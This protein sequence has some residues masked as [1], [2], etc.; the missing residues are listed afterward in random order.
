MEGGGGGDPEVSVATQE[1]ESSLREEKAAKKELEEAE[2]AAPGWMSNFPSS[3]LR[4]AVGSLEKAAAPHRTSP[5]RDAAAGRMDD[6]SRGRQRGR[7]E[8]PPQEEQEHGRKGHGHGHGQGKD[9]AAAT[10]GVAPQAS[11]LVGK[12]REG[13]TDDVMLKR[14]E[15]QFSTALTDAEKLRRRAALQR[16]EAKKASQEHR[17]GS[18]AAPESCGLTSCVKAAAAHPS[19]SQEARARMGISGGKG[20]SEGDKSLLGAL[21]SK[22]TVIHKVSTDEGALQRLIKRQMGVVT[23]KIA[24]TAQKVHRS[25]RPA[26]G[27]EEG[28]RQE[29]FKR[30]ESV[31]ATRQAAR[32]LLKV[33]HGSK[34]PW[35]VKTLKHIASDA[36]QID[37]AKGRID[38]IKEGGVME[39]CSVEIEGLPKCATHR[40]SAK[41]AEEREKQEAARLLQHTLD[42]AAAAKKKVQEGET[43]RRRLPASV[44]AQLAAAAKI[45]EG[46]GKRKKT[47]VA[48]PAKLVRTP[49][50]AKD[51]PSSWFSAKDQEEAVPG[52]KAGHQ[53][54]GRAQN[55]SRKGAKGESG[56]V[57][58]LGRDVVRDLSQLF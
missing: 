41:E 42:L 47:H 1:F 56:V 2:E 9:G 40:Q 25:N 50:E 58:E 43:R 26:K 15:S 49:E 31:A 36:A 38:R 6:G 57:G 27:G 30:Q 46:G 55:G 23:G 48:A 32:Q 35:L 13:T 18:S 4:S 11:H 29:D 20:L 7:R 53:T 19:A 5:E 12:E 21:F 37:E 8:R 22:N 52:A 51:V 24:L 39:P 17:G 14:L 33:L 34:D 16:A 3:V 28:L 10:A 44:Q 45:V 54:A